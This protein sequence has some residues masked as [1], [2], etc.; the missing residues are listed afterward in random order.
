MGVNTTSI[1]VKHVF[2]REKC[3]NVHVHFKLD[4]FEWAL[5]ASVGLLKTHRN[6]PSVRTNLRLDG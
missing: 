3:V 6:Q 5:V 4:G 1:L 2:T